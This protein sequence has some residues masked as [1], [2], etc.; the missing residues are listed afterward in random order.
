MFT[1]G[2]NW[3]GLKLLAYTSGKPALVRMLLL[4]NLTTNVG[5]EF[6]RDIAQCVQHD[7][8]A[9]DTERVP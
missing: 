5:P 4:V 1:N 2:Y 8:R 7:V 6:L 3:L 9:P